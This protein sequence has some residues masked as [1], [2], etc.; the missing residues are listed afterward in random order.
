MALKIP[1]TF[2][3]GENRVP[4]EAKNLLREF[5]GH[6]DICDEC[7]AAIETRSARYCATGHS[8]IAQLLELPGVEL[9]PD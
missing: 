2:I 1:T 9:V 5:A 4:P 6:R 8:L 7:T 3:G